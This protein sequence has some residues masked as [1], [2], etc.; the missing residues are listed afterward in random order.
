MKIQLAKLTMGLIILCSI[1]SNATNQV[2]G[3]SVYALSDKNAT[4]IIK[5]MNSPNAIGKLR[6]VRD[7]RHEMS[8]K[9]K[10]GMNITLTHDEAF[11]YENSHSGFMRRYRS[12]GRVLVEIGIN[13]TGLSGSKGFKLLDDES[14]IIYKIYGAKKNSALD[15]LGSHRKINGSVTILCQSVKECNAQYEF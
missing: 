8:I 14:E 11:D 3:A 1:E 7:Y 15:V 13:D 2:G 6:D 12:D 10:T 5:Y 9:T 4:R